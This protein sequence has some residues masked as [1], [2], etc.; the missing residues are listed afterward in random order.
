[1]IRQENKI[2]PVR[3]N[4]KIQPFLPTLDIWAYKYKRFY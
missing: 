4:E 3:E 2:V 1:V